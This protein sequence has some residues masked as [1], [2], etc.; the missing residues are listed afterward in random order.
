MILCEHLFEH[1]CLAN[2]NNGIK[3]LAREGKDLAGIITP[4]MELKENST[5]L[6]SPPIALPQV[7]AAD[8]SLSGTHSRC[9]ISMDQ[10]NFKPVLHYCSYS[11]LNDFRNEI[12]LMFQRVSVYIIQLNPTVEIMNQDTLGIWNLRD[13]CITVMDFSFDSHCVFLLSKLRMFCALFTSSLAWMMET[14]SQT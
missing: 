5:F 2:F 10:V 6:C 4:A 13:V 9:W 14:W 1:S 12:I 7:S 3:D 8:W 11:N